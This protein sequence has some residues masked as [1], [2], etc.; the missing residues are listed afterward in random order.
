MRFSKCIWVHELIGRASCGWARCPGCG[1]EVSSSTVLWRLV[2][3]PGVDI[4]H[5]ASC[6]GVFKYIMAQNSNFVGISFRR[7][8]S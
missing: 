2:E 3:L 4:A 5:Q 8:G 6:C 7:P 1:R